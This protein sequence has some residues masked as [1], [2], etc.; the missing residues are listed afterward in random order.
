[1]HQVTGPDDL[2]LP[3]GEIR[4][5]SIVSAECLMRVRLMLSAQ[6]GTPFSGMKEVIRDLK[7]HGAD[8]F[9]ASGD[10]MRTG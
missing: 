5:P 10:S 7:G 9:V 4:V 8:I 6:E 2:A 1:M 3:Y